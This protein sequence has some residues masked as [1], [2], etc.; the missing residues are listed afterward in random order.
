MTISPAAS[1]FADA[2]RHNCCVAS[3]SLTRTVPRYCISSCSIADPVARDWPNNFA[4]SIKKNSDAPLSASALGV[5]HFLQHRLDRLSSSLSKCPKPT[6]NAES[7]LRPFRVRPCSRFSKLPCWSSVRHVA[8]CLTDDTPT[9][10]CELLAEC[11]T[12]PAFQAFF[13][14]ANHFGTGLFPCSPPQRRRITSAAYS[15]KSLSTSHAQTGRQCD[16]DSADLCGYLF[17]NDPPGFGTSPS[18]EAERDRNSRILYV[19]ESHRL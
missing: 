9:A 6:S 12:P 8:D 5:V 13:H 3:T 17:H 16:R 15:R 1:H 10:F 14:I 7:V 2:H 19:R 4:L 11:G 18:A